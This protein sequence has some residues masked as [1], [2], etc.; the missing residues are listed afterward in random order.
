MLNLKIFKIISSNII[1]QSKENKN[2]KEPTKFK[3]AAKYWF[4]N[5]NYK[6]NK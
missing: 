3:D 6:N 4:L 2:K 1:M 5:I